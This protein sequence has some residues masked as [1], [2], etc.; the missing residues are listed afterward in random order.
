MTRTIAGV[1]IVAALGLGLGAQ[2]PTSQYR[3]LGYQVVFLITQDQRVTRALT[4]N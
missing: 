4:I 2:A 3:L 1:A